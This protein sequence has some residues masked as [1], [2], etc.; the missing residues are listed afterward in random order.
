[1]FLSFTV[2]KRISFRVETA[3]AL[4]SP[5]ERQ[6]IEMLSKIL[7]SSA[8]SA[9]PR[10]CSSAADSPRGSRWQEAC[11]SVVN[12][13]FGY[14]A[15]YGAYADAVRACRSWRNGCAR[16]PALALPGNSGESSPFAAQLWHC[17]HFLAEMPRAPS[18]SG[19]ANVCWPAA[20][21]FWHCQ[22]FLPLGPNTPLSSGSAKDFC[23]PRPVRHP[24]LALPGI[25]GVWAP[26]SRTAPFPLRQSSSAR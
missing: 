3:F 8:L 12:G 20:A 7:G 6:H 15:S 14:A 2:E 26:R 5:L 4:T 25:S 11:L 17:Q 13:I 23:H 19:T 10:S 1:M 18:S 9:W 16:H 22:E 24:A 21:F